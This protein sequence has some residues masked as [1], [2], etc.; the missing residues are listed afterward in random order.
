M[1]LQLAV[2]LV[3]TLTHVV[4]VDE[5]VMR[6][7]S[8]LGAVWAV[9]HDLDP[10]LGM[11]HLADDVVQLVDGLTTAI[12]S[13]LALELANRNHS[14]VVADCQMLERGQVGESSGLAVSWLLAHRACTATLLLF[15]QLLEVID[16]LDTTFSNALLTLRV[17]HQNGVV[18]TA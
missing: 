14:V 18:I 17:V 15:W 4:N 9:T 11:V 6:A 16:N 2:W 10:L 3:L 12:L 5:V 13:F 7:N 1:S 8:Q